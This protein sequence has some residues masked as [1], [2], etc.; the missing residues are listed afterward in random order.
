MFL[1]DQEFDVTFAANCQ[2]K[3]DKSIADDIV[4]QWLTE[5]PKIDWK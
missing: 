5:T 3:D 4:N 2:N 1:F